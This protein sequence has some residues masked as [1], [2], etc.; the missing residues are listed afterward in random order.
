MSTEFLLVAARNLA[1]LAVLL[2]LLQLWFVRFR[3]VQRV[4][5]KIQMRLVSHQDDGVVLD[6]ETNLIDGRFDL[7]LMKAG[8]K[9]SPSRLWFMLMTVVVIG[10]VVT[11]LFGVLTGLFVP[12]GALVLAGL[13]WNL[14]YQKRRRLVFDS[15]PGII[16]DVIRGI[17]AGRSLEQALVE[18]FRDAHEVFDLFAFRLRSAVDAGRDYTALMDDFANIY[19]VP[20]LVFVAVALRTSS[21]FGSAIRPIL[22]KVSA[23][24]RTQ[25][26]M[27]REFMAATA[28]TRLTAVAFAVLPIGIG[29]M[30]MA[31][32]E[33]FRKILLETE[34]GHSML[35]VSLTL[36]A[37][38]TAI[39][40]RM[41]QG[42]GRG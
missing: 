27:R 38:S 36:I 34:S 11:V 20:P 28:E 7:V 35:T 42:V 25:Q 39:I 12:L 32:N 19:K 15:L 31:S 26:E 17:D 1:I 5:Q 40:L 10:L 37:I 41:V 29:V 21:R 4:R 22:K 2:L 9:I 14:R 8:L 33:S 24:L 3:S 18:S 23:S 13:F 30:L 16:D 6:Q